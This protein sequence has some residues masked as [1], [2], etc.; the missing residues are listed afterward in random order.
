MNENKIETDITNV[1][2]QRRS[3]KFKR[4]EKKQNK[5]RQHT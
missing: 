3:Y 1:N 2:K 4:F 5:N